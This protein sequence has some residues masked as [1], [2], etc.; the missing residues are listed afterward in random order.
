MGLDHQGSVSRRG[1]GGNGVKGERRGGREG[2]GRL[3][4]IERERETMLACGDG[5]FYLLGVAVKG[6]RR[7]GRVGKR[8]RG[9]ECLRVSLRV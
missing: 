3:G 1:G 6:E 5:S 2:K 4:E 7:E 9:R 8:E